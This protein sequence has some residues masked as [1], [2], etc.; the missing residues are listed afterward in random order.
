[1]LVQDDGRTDLPAVVKA[2]EECLVFLTITTP[3]EHGNYRWEVDLVHEMVA[4]FKERGSP[5]AQGEVQIRTSATT[6]PPSSTAGATDFLSP[7][8][9]PSSPELEERGLDEK[10][11]NAL[12]PETGGPEDA[13]MFGIPRA[14]VVDFFESRGD[15]VL[16]IDEDSHA[17]R[18]WVGFRYYVRRAQ[19]S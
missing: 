4:W 11:K 12:S 16:Q 8:A 14:D 13:P 7:S 10:L 15:S 9:E 3:P 5:T 19:E 2:G 17:G 6:K 1:M 18:E